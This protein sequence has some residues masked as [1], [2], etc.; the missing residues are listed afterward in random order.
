MNL[1]RDRNLALVGTVSLLLA[2]GVAFVPSVAALLRP[3]AG[4][5]G[6][7]TVLLV[8]AVAGL[9]GLWSFKQGVGDTDEADLWTPQKLPERAYYDE[10]RTAGADVDSVLDEEEVMAGPRNEARSRIR[11]TAV[12]VVANAQDCSGGEANG[13]LNDGSWTD[14]PRAAAFFAERGVAD[15]PLRARI[16]DWAS[17]E[18]FERQARHAVAE[19]ERLATTDI[20]SRRRPQHTGLFADDDESV[21]IAGEDLGEIYNK[22]DGTSDSSANDSAESERDAT[23]SRSEQLGDEPPLTPEMRATQSKSGNQQIDDE[24]NRERDDPDG[25]KALQQQLL[26]DDLE[27]SQ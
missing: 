1:L 12:S 8:G 16:R 24:L 21:P 22:S 6:Q 27:G 20:E 4:L 11:K 19:M 5:T 25:D 7:G 14:D 10:H 13:R 9:L 15:V 23:E 3:L 26:A 17:G 18:A 2:L